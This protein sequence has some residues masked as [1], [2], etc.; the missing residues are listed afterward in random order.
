MEKLTNKSCRRSL[1]DR[2]AEEMNN[3]EST[4]NFSISRETTSMN[5]GNSLIGENTNLNKPHDCKTM[6]K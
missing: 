1:F 6:V 2:F 4:S 5:D 3:E